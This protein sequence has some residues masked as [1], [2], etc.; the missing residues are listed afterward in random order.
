[1]YAMG[2]RGLGSLEPDPIP[3]ITT[4][5]QRSRVADVPVLIANATRDGSTPLVWAERMQAVFDRPMI[6]YRSSE[7]V[8][9]GR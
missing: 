6:K 9:G 7:H 2:C 8:I 3:L 5:R 1:M 4:D